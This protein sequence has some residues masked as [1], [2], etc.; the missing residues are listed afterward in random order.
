M[1]GGALP[2]ALLAAALGFALSFAPRRSLLVCVPAFAA[3]ALLTT[4]L[5]VQA[6]WQ[7]A[8]FLGCWTSVVITAA[9]VHLPGGLN[10]RLALVLALNAGIWCGAVIAAAGTP[11]DLAKAAPWVLLA[12][13]G[14]W[15]VGRRGGVAIKVLSSWLAAVAILGAALQVTTPTPGYVAD[16]ME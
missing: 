8:M 2:P 7:D 3:A 4:F 10:A 15:L 16:H 6:A 5:S 14:V 12:V 1:R 9:A 13:P 11:L